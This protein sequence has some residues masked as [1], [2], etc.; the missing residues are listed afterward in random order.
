LTRA[1]RYI[2]L[3]IGLAVGTVLV[4]LGLGGTVFGFLDWIKQ[5]PWSLDRVLRLALSSVF[6]L[7]L[8]AQVICSSFFLS[9]LGLR[10]RSV[11]RPVA[12]TERTGTGS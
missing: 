9:I 1:F 5:E 12:Q 2:T 8:G 4:V 6:S 3:E 7:T 10:R 11:P